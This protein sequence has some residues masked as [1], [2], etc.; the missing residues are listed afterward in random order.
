MVSDSKKIA[1]AVKSGSSDALIILDPNN[2]KDRIKKKFNI[3]GI[4]RP[5]WNPI[6]NQI[7]FIGYKQF[8]S[9][10]FIYDLDNDS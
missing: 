6:K 5:K 2:P 8:A 3:E 9:D 7:A 1:F 10:V 4:Y